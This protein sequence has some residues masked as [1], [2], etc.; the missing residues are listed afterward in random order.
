[1]SDRLAR[2]GLKLIPV[3]RATLLKEHGD[4]QGTCWDIELECGHRLA[5]HLRRQC[6]EI[7]PVRAGCREC[8]ASSPPARQPPI[9]AG[10]R[11]GLLVAVESVP[12]TLSRPAWRFRCE[13]GA[14]HVA[15]IENVRGG[16]TRSCGCMRRARAVGAR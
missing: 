15:T 13:C 7:A 11:Y 9:Q 3:T 6:A 10:Q 12:S 14:R 2:N 16:K 8:T 5:H 4:E 1:M